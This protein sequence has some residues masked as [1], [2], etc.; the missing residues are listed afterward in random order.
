MNKLRSIFQQVKKNKTSYIFISPFFVMFFLF[1]IF[2]IFYSFYI[3]L[4]RMAY[5][6]QNPTFVGLG[7]YLTLFSDKKFLNSLLVTAKYVVF[8]VSIM[9][10]ASVLSAILLNLWWIKLRNLFRT[11]F[12]A[13]VVTSLVV[14][15]AIFSL[16]FSKDRGIVNVILTSVGLRGYDWLSDPRLA[17]WTLIVIG[18]WR[19]TGYYMVIVLAGLQNIPTE[20]YDSARIDGA[21]EFRITI[22]I[23]LPLL[24]PV[25]FFTIVMGVIY[26]LQLF[27]EPYV[28]TQGGP[29]D[30]TLSLALYQFYT[31]F[32]YL[33][34][35]YGSA[36][37][38]FL[39]L[40]IAL[41]TGLQLGLFRRVGGV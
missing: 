1:F 10:I 9:T 5:T 37:A 31:S 32:R 3:S 22:R 6:L 35:G 23:T 7:N 34:F 27:V 26:A 15:A 40:L 20:L 30:S 11:A 29:A 28:L 13:P 14:T 2:P 36:I 17:L 38:Y 25:I 33:N 21:G 24:S 8:Q 39:T 16:I 19:W 12:I 18:V 4:H 41:I